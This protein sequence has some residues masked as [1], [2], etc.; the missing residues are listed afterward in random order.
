MTV[1]RMEGIP[2]QQGPEV[3]YEGRELREAAELRA[4]EYLVL[5]YI[6][7]GTVSH[8]CGG[9]T[10]WAQPGDYFFLDW[11]A[12]H[13]LQCLD[14]P[15]A[16]NCCF[17]RPIL[18][19]REW[20]GCRRLEDLLRPYLGGEEGHV[21]P[22]GT[23]FS[24]DSGRVGEAV[25]RIAE[26]YRDRGAAYSQMI[27]AY[28]WQILIA[29]LRQWDEGKAALQPDD[30]L[31]I[32]HTVDRRWGE[33]LRLEDFARRLGVD[34]SY[35]SRRF[36]AVCGCGFKEYLQARRMEEAARLLRQTDRR[37]AEVAQAVGYRDSAFFRR[38]FKSRWGVPPSRYR[39]EGENL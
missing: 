26:E 18:L 21:P 4:G 12:V 16:V 28:L 5:A 36:T 38:L 19:D 11:E 14:G 17:F 2:A 39:R 33:D 10:R 34:P 1:R 24:D 22:A 9:Q 13:V 20:G 32:R 37:I 23:V 31:M 25:A 30:L 27:R 8:T 6:R 29:A 7:K 35:L 15:A 3:I